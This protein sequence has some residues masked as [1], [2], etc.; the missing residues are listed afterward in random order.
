MEASV[1]QGGIVQLV[2]LPMCLQNNW[3]QM[4]VFFT[5]VTWGLY[6]SADYLPIDNG[7]VNKVRRRRWRWR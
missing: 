1:L 7:V 3:S 6:G 2:P 4:F 5:N